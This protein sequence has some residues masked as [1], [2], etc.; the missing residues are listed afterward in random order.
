M[1]ICRGNLLIAAIGFAAYRVRETNEIS[2]AFDRA[3]KHDG[4]ALLELVLDPEAISSRASLIKIR[5]AALISATTRS[6]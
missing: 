5:A 4:P 6:M 2:A 3:L 1:P